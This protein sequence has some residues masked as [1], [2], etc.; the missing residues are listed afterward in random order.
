MFYQ[1]PNSKTAFDV[2]MSNNPSFAAFNS[3]ASGFHDVPISME[4][5]KYNE[6]QKQKDFDNKLNL[7]KQLLSHENQLQQQNLKFKLDLEKQ[8]A[9]DNLLRQLKIQYP[10]QNFSNVDDA[11]LHHK[12]T[13]DYNN[14]VK[15][16]TGYSIPNF[17]QMSV[18]YGSVPTMNTN[19]PLSFANSNYPQVPP[20]KFNE[21]Q[22]LAVPSDVQQEA[23]ALVDTA[24]VAGEAS[25]DPSIYQ[26]FVNQANETLR[27]EAQSY[28]PRNVVGVNNDR[29][30]HNNE[31]VDKYIDN[32][33][34]LPDSSSGFIKDMLNK[35]GG[36]VPADFGNEGWYDRRFKTLDDVQAQLQTAVNV[37]DKYQGKVLEKTDP[38]YLDL[39]KNYNLDYTL[40]QYGLNAQEIFFIRSP[41]GVKLVEISPDADEKGNR[42]FN[43]YTI[44]SQNGNIGIIKDAKGI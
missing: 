16:N 24:N 31:I 15:G 18:G 5:A 4:L 17:N 42:P 3:I 44:T 20:S 32:S 12:R 6:A 38:F 33:W 13:I 9:D 23:A 10:D 26:E 7:S 2:A 39:L 25:L 34:I 22:M 40:G 28:T 21:T 27:N 35:Y 11:L 29:S 19:V 41:Y 8:Y 1:N 30:Q 37:A 36:A 43:V 14:A